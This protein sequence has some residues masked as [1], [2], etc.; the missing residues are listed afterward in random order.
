VFQ[1][2][3]NETPRRPISQMMDGSMKAEIVSHTQKVDCCLAACHQVC[4]RNEVAQLL[5]PVP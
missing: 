3:L 5:I 2:V 4:A 1:H